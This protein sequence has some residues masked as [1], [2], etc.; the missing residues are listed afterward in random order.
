MNDRYLYRAKLTDNG[1]WVEG[2]YC[3]W[4]KGKL[5]ITYSEKEVDCIITWMSNGGMQR[6]EV[7]PSTICQCTGLKDKNGKLIFENDLVEIKGTVFQCFWNNANFEW[8]FKNNSEDF[9]IAYVSSDDIRI[10]GNIFDNP[11][12]LEV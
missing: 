10:V 3:K 1:E 11:E 4:I 2:F 9:G 7:D 12:L 8:G 6:F 5:V